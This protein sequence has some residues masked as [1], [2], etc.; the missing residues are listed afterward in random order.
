L[1]HTLD[2]LLGGHGRARSS[3]PKESQ[4]CHFVARAQVSPWAIGFVLA[5]LFVAWISPADLRADTTLNSGTTT[6]HSGT[7]FGGKLYVATTGIATL[8][9][10][11]GMA[12]SG[13][14]WL[15]SSPGGNGT[16]MVSSGTWA[17]SGDIIIGDKGTGS[18]KVTGGRVIS[19]NGILGNSSNGTGTATVSSGTWANSGNLTVGDKGTGTLSMT[20]G[21]VTNTNG[22]LGNSSNG[23]GTATVSGGTWANSGDLIVGLLGE[24][25]LTISGSGVVSVA[26]TLSKGKDS[27]ISL[28]SGGTLLIG[29]GG[30]S[31]SLGVSALRNNGTL[32]FN[33]SDASTYSGIIS[34]TGSVS[35]QGAGT[36][37]LSGNNTFSGVTTIT[38]GSLSIGAGG[39]AGSIA[40]NV[41]DN[42]TLVFNRSDASTYSGIISGTGSVTKQGAGT[43]T[44]TAHNSYSGLTT[45]SGGTLALSGSGSI[46]TGGLNLGNNGVFDI[47][48]VTSGTSW[49]PVTGDLEG[50]GTLR[51]RSHT[52]AVLGSFMPG[53]SVGIVTVDAG[54]TLDLSGAK[55]TTFE[56]TSP[57]F[58]AGTYDLVNGNGSVIFGG[59]FNLVFSGGSFANGTNVLKL[60]T[61]TGAL[62]GHF[63]EVNSTGLAAGQHV[64]FSDA[65][66]YISISAIPEPST[67]ALAAIGAGIVGLMHWRKR[68]TAKIAAKATA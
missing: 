52:L 55:S 32:V 44:L 42:G 54:L 1:A 38:T 12:T 56:I 46:G 23:T 57:S 6:V 68:R 26:G 59:S 24:S 17:N 27:T 20:G 51:G 60:F 14:G 58:T 2:K 63:T 8:N 30:T 37:T 50:P 47:S 19:T 41:V 66:G 5:G 33:R 45:I 11:G 67:Y 31:G 39:T 34:G 7:N 9:V 15:G 25:M 49:L 62:A 16:V 53:N 40:G 36:L 35:K 48:S 18:L 61:N 21:S 43:L 13:T 65:T 3:I 10:T 64:T 29:I 4:P 22:I 28:N